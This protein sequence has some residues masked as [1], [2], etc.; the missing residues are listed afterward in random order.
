LL[1]C[2]C[3]PAHKCDPAMSILHLQA[4]THCACVSVNELQAA[5]KAARTNGR[6]RARIVRLLLLRPPSATAA[7][8][9]ITT[10]TVLLVL[11]PSMLSVVL[12]MITMMMLLFTPRPHHI[13]RLQR[14]DKRRRQRLNLMPASTPNRGRESHTSTLTAFTTTGT[15]LIVPMAQVFVVRWRG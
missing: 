3:C 10:T 5:R 1:T 4:L 11:A 2:Y 9:R 14:L 12:M 15:G 8:P 7:V 13:T 6:P